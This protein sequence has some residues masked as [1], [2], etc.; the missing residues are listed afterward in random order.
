M[1]Y[2]L[3]NDIQK[4]SERQDKVKAENPGYDNSEL[5]EQIIW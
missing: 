2:R 3:F 5:E 4:L 1:F